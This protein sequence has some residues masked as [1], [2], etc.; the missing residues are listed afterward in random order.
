[1]ER[2]VVPP[3]HGL[4][5]GFDQGKR[6]EGRLRRGGN[7]RPQLARLVEVSARNGAEICKSPLEPRPAAPRDDILAHHSMAGQ[8]IGWNEDL[9]L[10]RMMRKGTQEPGDSV[11]DACMACGIRR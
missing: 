8:D 5:I 3:L 10:S 11:G 2:I 9:P 7:G 4:E 1:M 6:L